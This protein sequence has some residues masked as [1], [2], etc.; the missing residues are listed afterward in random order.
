MGKHAEWAKMLRDWYDEAENYS[1][2]LF[3]ANN[4]I[5]K[6]DLLR[7]VDEDEEFARAYDYA[8]TVMEFKVTD[9]MLH[10][11]IDRG[12]GT[13]LLETY[14]GWKGSE[15]GKEV[16][17]P[18]SPEVAERLIDA[19]D[20][21][22]DVRSVALSSDVM[23]FGEVVASVPSGGSASPSVGSASP[24]GGVDG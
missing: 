6:K 24:S 3:A 18:L 21:L 23:G 14:C 19:V 5:S 9:G 11:E 7:M 15:V 13:R 22:S 4:E 12:V 17:V 10:G 8:L 20:R 16:A 1:I 2:V